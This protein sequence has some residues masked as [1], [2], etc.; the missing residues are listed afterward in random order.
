M[1]LL[2]YLD[3]RTW[4]SRDLPTQ[5]NLVG[6]STQ[7]ET[8][9]LA[10]TVSV[11]TIHAALRQAEQGDTERLFAL[12]RDIRLG[13]AHTQTLYN[14]RKLAVL[15]KAMSIVPAD[16]K[17][18]ADRAA[19]EACKALTAS[20]GWLTQGL[21]HLL[22]GHLYP[23][24]VMEQTYR[25]APGGNALRYLPG[26][27]RPVPYRL[28]DWTNGR[29]Q[30]CDADRITGARMATRQDPEPLRHVIHRGHLLTDVP[31][32][33]GGPM[34]AVL[35]WWLFA[36][37]DRDWWVRFLDRF[38]A[39]FLVAK[40]DTADSKSQRT[41]TTAFSQATRLFGLVVS[42]ETDVNVH[43][44]AT[45][46][47]GEAFRVFQEFANS[48]LSKLI[49]GQTMTVTAQAGGLGGAQAEVQDATKD[50]IRAW[51]L[52][53]LSETVN[54]QIIQPFLWINGIL[55]EAVL[56]VA[57][58]SGQD[59]RDKTEFLTAAAKI[60]LEPTDDAVE[61][62]SKSSGVQL[63]RSSRPAMPFG[64]TALSAQASPMDRANRRLDELGWPTDEQLDKIAERGAPDL[65]AAFVGR[66]APVRDIIA[67]ST[68]E[69]DLSR[70]LSEWT[71]TLE[72]G[73]AAEIMAEALTAYAAT[74]TIP[75]R[76]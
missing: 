32:Q 6:I 36:T 52:A 34:R 12:Y 47:H 40:Y 62:L 35:F 5:S 38:G 7:S 72:P 50:D 75:R 2:S 41:L 58:D 22:N 20:P 76:R 1:S 42:R 10:H 13:H 59:L 48:E 53:A 54:A 65:A 74:G 70:R 67:A 24:A 46:S 68:S 45:Q 16:P 21:N 64:L 4:F 60:G 14:Q 55:G 15:T 61:Q 56:Q 11:D 25:A 44:V 73:R 33:W 71:A 19:A 69:E 29:L 37:Q 27:W 26:Q 9:A 23:V 17:S 39:P 49:L 31:D 28:L 66:Y 8:P 51:D 18:P 43:A 3:P 63:Q 30:I 57:A